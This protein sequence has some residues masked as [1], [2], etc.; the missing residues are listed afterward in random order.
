MSNKS[1]R[2]GD[3][4]R[5]MLDID[6]RSS[7]SIGTPKPDGWYMKLDSSERDGNESQ[8]GRVGNVSH[9]D[10]PGTLFYLL[11]ILSVLNLGRTFDTPSCDPVLGR[12][13]C[14]LLLSLCFHLAW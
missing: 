5:N 2:Q 8:R 7:R 9:N 10:G 4:W 3:T 14:S 11:L 1:L 13:S 12:L 6:F